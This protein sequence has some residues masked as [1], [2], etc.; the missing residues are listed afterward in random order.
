[1]TN[2]KFSQQISGFELFAFVKFNGFKVVF[3]RQKVLDRH[4]LRHENRPG[5]FVVFGATCFGEL[6]NS[7]GGFFLRSFW[8]G[9]ILNALGFF[10]TQFILLDW[11]LG[12]FH[13]NCYENT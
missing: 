12:L 7:L 13:Q 10:K 5:S 3:P 8:G 2:L 11:L 6:S 1:M 4:P 9:L